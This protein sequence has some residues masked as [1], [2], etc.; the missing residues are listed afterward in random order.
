MPQRPA[1]AA[2]WKPRSAG[3]SKVRVRA[4]GNLIAAG[5]K[6]KAGRVSVFRPAEAS[7][8]GP[9]LYGNGVA[10]GG[11]LTASTNA[12]EVACDQ[13]IVAPAT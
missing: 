7:Y 5:S 11:T 3:T 12:P 13:P 1:F 4:A 9:G 8:Y 10:C 6:T 2:T